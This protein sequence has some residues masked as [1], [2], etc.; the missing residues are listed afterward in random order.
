MLRAQ[1][2]TYPILEAFKSGDECPFCFLERQAEQ[3]TI[4]YVAGPGASY[5]EPDVRASTAAKS[6]LRGFRMV[7]INSS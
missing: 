6:V 4:R 2:D 3:S 5:M 1:L 7:S